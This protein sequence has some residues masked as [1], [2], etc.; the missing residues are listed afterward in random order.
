MSCYRFTFDLPKHRQQ[1]NY[2]RFRSLRDILCRMGVFRDAGTF[3]SLLR[4][5][6]MVESTGRRLISD[7]I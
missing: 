7:I 2:D 4:G 3:G 6:V 5:G 1:L